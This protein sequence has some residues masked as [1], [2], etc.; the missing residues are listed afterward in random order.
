MRFSNIL[1]FKFS[2]EVLRDVFKTLLKCK[3]RRFAKIDNGFQ[4]LNIFV[5]G[6][7]LNV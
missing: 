7:I 4:P 3:V 6:F 5:K 1:Y 2:S